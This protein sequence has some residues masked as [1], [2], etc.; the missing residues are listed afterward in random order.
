MADVAKTSA[1]AT[2]ASSH[3][4]WPCSNAP[5]LRGCVRTRRAAE[6]KWRCGTATGCGRPA[7]GRDVAGGGACWRTK[8]AAGAAKE[9][10]M[11]AGGG[12]FGR[13]TG[14]GAG[15]FERRRGALPSDTR[16]GG[17]GGGFYWKMSGEVGAFGRAVAAAVEPSEKT[18][19]VGEAC[20]RRRAE[21][22][23]GAWERSTAVEGEA[24]GKWSGG[25]A[26]V[27]GKKTT[28]EEAAEGRRR[29][30]EVGEAAQGLCLHPRWLRRNS[31]SLFSWGVSGSRGTEPRCPG[32]A[33]LPAASPPLCR[34]P[35]CVR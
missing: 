20:E 25:T 17:E 33:E 31:G 22:E 34:R 13:T 16:T 11:G 23:G 35:S 2:I 8:G 9:T 6:A 19:E 14:V 15:A 27:E 4:A 29:W 26:E 21:G 32:A 3:S 1:V 7:A 18:D 10:M 5:A 30:G 28:V 24:R 12:T